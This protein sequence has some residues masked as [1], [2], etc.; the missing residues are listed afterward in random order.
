MKR[1]NFRCGLGVTAYSFCMARLLQSE[2]DAKLLRKS[3]ILAHTHKTDKQIVDLFSGLADEYRGTFYS[4]DM[5]HLCKE[6][7]AHQRSPAAR[8]VRGAVLQCFPRQTV[9]FFV[10]LGAFISIATLINTV[11]AVYRFYHPVNN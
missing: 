2:A 5:L 8:A 3:G 6:V 4:K 11:F 1:N 9:T 10:I 7:A